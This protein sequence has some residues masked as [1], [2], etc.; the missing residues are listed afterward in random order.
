MSEEKFVKNWK[1]KV[2]TAKLFSC[3]DK[4]RGFSRKGSDA[5]GLGHRAVGPCPAPPWVPP[6]L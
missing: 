5:Q 1:M 6:Q 2:F 4:V 3:W